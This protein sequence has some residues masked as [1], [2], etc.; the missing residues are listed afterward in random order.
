MGGGPEVEKWD[1]TSFCSRWDRPTA[2]LLLLQPVTPPK[3]LST[4]GRAVAPAA[5][6]KLRVKAAPAA[7]SAPQKAASAAAAASLCALLALGTPDAALAREV[8]PYAGLTPCASNAAFAKRERNEV[9]TLTKR[10]AKARCT[11]VG[12]ARRAGVRPAGRAWLGGPG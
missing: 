5:P 12:A 11:R 9:K 4:S 6:A 3:M 1:N 7:V 8:A 10:L 2:K